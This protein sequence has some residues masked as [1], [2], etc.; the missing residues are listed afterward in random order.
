M[1]EARDEER[2]FQ[3]EAIILT[4]RPTHA[5]LDA[6]KLQENYESIPFRRGTRH[7]WVIISSYLVISPAGISWCPCPGT[8]GFAASKGREEVRAQVSL[9]GFRVGN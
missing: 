8:T 9:I 3:S 2:P 5:C 1:T 7:R 6:D 4:E